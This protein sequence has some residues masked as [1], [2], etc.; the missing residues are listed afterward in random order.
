MTNIK[1]N[2]LFIVAMVLLSTLSILAFK[3]TSPDEA[4][5]VTSSQAI[6]IANGEG[7][8]HCPRRR[9]SKCNSREVWHYVGI[10]SGRWDM[11]VRMWSSLVVDVTTR[12]YDSWSF[13]VGSDGGVSGGHW[14]W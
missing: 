12:W 5:A 6:S 2:K 13:R 9:L 7:A 4:G 3:A 10:G 11:T 8:A 1:S 14:D